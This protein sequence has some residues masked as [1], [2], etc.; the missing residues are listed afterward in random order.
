MANLPAS[1]FERLNKIAESLR[2]EIFIIE[3][4]SHDFDGLARHRK[5]VVVQWDAD[6]FP[7]VREQKIFDEFGER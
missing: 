3:A 7:E 4:C 6:H 5:G 1:A 2:V